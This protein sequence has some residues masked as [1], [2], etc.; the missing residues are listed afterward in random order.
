MAGLGANVIP[1]PGAA[2]TPQGSPDT[3]DFEAAVRS[4]LEAQN[5]LPFTLDEDAQRKFVHFFHDEVSKALEGRTGFEKKVEQWIRNYEQLPLVERREW[6]W[7]RASN[8]VVPITSTGVDA[9]FAQILST[10]FGGDR[11]WNI[12]ISQS[13]V[14]REP[15]E[16][17]SEYLEWARSNDFNLY[18]VAVDAILEALK[19][20]TS[21]IKAG[22]QS[23]TEKTRTLSK[24]GMSVI[25]EMPIKDGVH[26]QAVRLLDFIVPANAR[27]IQTSRWV[28]HRITG[29]SWGDLK[30]WE[31]RGWLSNVEKIKTWYSEQTDVQQ[32]ITNRAIGLEEYLHENSYDIYEVWGKYDIDGDGLEEEIKLRFHY[33][34]QTYLF[35]MYNDNIRNV[36]PFFR[37]RFFP[38]EHSFY[39]IGLGEML[40]QIQEEISTIHNQ[41]I[42]NATIANAACVKM[43]KGTYTGRAGAGHI[44]PGKRFMVDDMAD[45]EPFN[46]GVGHRDTKTDEMMSQH[47]AERRTGVTDYILGRE[48]PDVGSRATA[49]S[50]TALLHQGN[51]RFELSIKDMRE[52]F[53]RLGIFII[54]LYQVN[55]PNG[56]RWAKY[57]P[58][59]KMA[60]DQILQL[61]PEDVYDN[62]YVDLATTSATLNRELEKQ[63]T[64][65]LFQILMVYYK[66]LMQAAQMLIPM[67]QQAPPLAELMLKAGDGAATMMK[68]IV[69]LS[70]MKDPDAI[71]PS[72]RDVLGGGGMPGGMQGGQ[73]GAEGGEAAG[74]AAGPSGSEGQSVLAGLASLLSGAG[75]QP[76]S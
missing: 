57:D 2:I 52:T 27:D 67:V 64:T 40:D 48:S 45:V 44:F 37:L 24:N 6:P 59:K 72:L 70:D 34:S 61:P 22:Y 56:I 14:W 28:C 20:G 50:T 54:S 15:A 36:R 41:R 69:S 17:L 23:Y 25:Q 53:S 74:G 76:P 4:H 35:G 55:N 73:P 75:G 21:I 49:T 7:P 60:L 12:G 46:L 9:I 10:I 16:Q 63:N 65:G 43:K 39:G 47:Y 68:R 29:L 11:F 19:L 26:L 66:E 8:I 13:E 33:D 30:A 5:L 42:D 1:F 31:A 62:L 32:K 71:V 18:M 3:A 38:R 58:E 51:K